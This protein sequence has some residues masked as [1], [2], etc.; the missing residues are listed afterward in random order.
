[1]AEVAS[2][3]EEL[4]TLVSPVSSKAASAFVRFVFR[5]LDPRR[6]DRASCCSYIP[7]AHGDCASVRANENNHQ[8][9]SGGGAS[10]S[11]W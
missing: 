5:L 1:M 10:C 11:V 8:A 4:S 9:S 7:R 6:R 3:A 2:Q